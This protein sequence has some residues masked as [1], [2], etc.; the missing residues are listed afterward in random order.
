MVEVC[1]KRKGKY[2]FF[3]GENR[4]IF[5]NNVLDV[6]VSER[7][8]KLRRV[9][10]GDD[11][12]KFEDIKD[13]P[14]GRIDVIYN[15]IF[16][17]SQIQSNGLIPRITSIPPYGQRYTKKNLIQPPIVPCVCNCGVMPC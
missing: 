14:L 11:Y 12:I 1:V 2:L 5:N 6:W 10:I 17:H 13:F 9:E 4:N 7:R 15:Q 16:W 3:E 8:Y